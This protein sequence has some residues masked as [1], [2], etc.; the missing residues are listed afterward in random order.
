MGYGAL[1]KAF[2]DLA[3]QEDPFAEYPIIRIWPKR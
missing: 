3:R 1:L 2:E